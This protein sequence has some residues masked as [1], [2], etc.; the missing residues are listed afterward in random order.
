[1]SKYSKVGK[2][3]PCGSID[4]KY[5]RKSNQFDEDVARKIQATNE[6]QE[7]IR[8]LILENPNL[9]E[10]RYDNAI[11]VLLEIKEKYL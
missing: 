4:S 9:I 5:F 6:F 10:Q 1:M 8:D 2:V 7:K 11:E 3:A